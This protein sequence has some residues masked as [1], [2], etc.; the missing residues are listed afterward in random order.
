MK[1]LDYIYDR[2]AFTE[3]W[4]RATTNV[5]SLV[6]KPRDDLLY[7]DAIDI[8]TQK[9]YELAQTLLAFENATDFA[10][11]ILK[12]DP[13]TYFHHLFGKYPGFIHRSGNTYEDFFELM[14]RDPGGNIADALGVN[15]ERYVVMPLTGEWI[16]FG[17]RSWD[18]GVL[19]GPPAIM[20]CAKRFYPFFITP[21]ELFR[22]QP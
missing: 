2:A 19:Y 10:T 21:P 8:A 9:F 1:D 16:A 3:L 14:M 7:F 13:F 6:S 4:E 17:D 12:P 20:E 22:V 11:L 15:H 5:S 18:I